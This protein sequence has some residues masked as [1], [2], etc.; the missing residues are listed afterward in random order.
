VLEV[1]LAYV[2]VEPIVALEVEVLMVAKL[3]VC[4]FIFYLF[5]YFL[6]VLSKLPPFSINNL[7]NPIIESNYNVHPR[8]FKVFGLEILLITSFIWR[9]FHYVHLIMFKI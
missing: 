9:S 8:Q 5:L 6:E 3:L 2:G 1:A 4:F 7:G